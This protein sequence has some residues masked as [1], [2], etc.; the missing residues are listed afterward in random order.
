MK[1]HK[2]K[3]KIFRKDED[4]MGFAHYLQ[5][6]IKT[7]YSGVILTNVELIFLAATELDLEPKDVKEMLLD[8]LMHEVGHAIQDYLNMNLSEKQIR[9]I[10]KKYKKKYYK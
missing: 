2:L 4:K 8:T 1:K 6:S 5:P 3:I 10:I 9:S 7:E